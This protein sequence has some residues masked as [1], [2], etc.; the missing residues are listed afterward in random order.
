M[1]KL[2]RTETEKSIPAPSDK[3]GRQ[4]KKLSDF[5]NRYFEAGY[6]NEDPIERPTPASLE[7]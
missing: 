3:C 4:I 1:N 5:K 6:T 2:S 7:R